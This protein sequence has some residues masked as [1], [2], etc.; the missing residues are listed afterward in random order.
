[1]NNDEI[2][3][4]VTL[5]IE[6]SAT[7]GLA[8]IPF[9]NP[10]VIS[11]QPETGFYGEDSIVYKIAYQADATLYSTA[12]AYFTIVNNS[13]VNELSSIGTLKVMP[14]PATATVHIPLIM[15]NRGQ[16][17]LTITDMQG[18]TVYSAS[19]SGNEKDVYLNLD[20]LRIQSGIYLIVLK[21]QQGISANRL[22]VY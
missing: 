11:Y 13:G 18:K 6:N 16:A 17:T 21:D 1:L 15:N 19:L 7:H 10:N 4:P 2:Q 20:G 5:S 3:A 12:K 14:N 22:V 8:Y 9:A